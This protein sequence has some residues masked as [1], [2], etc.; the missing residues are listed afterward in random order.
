MSFCSVFDSITHAMCN[1]H[2]HTYTP[3]HMQ[4]GYEL[5]ASDHIKGSSVNAVASCVQ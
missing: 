3:T 5:E 4:A 1:T 2:A